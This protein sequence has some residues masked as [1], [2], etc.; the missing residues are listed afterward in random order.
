MIFITYLTIEEIYKAFELEIWQIRG[1]N[2]PLSAFLMQIISKILI[3]YKKMQDVRIQ[4]NI[5]SENLIPALPEKTT[6]QLRKL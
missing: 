1:Q 2:R 5:S 3:K 6:S 4:H